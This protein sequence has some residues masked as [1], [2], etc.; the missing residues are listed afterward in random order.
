MAALGLGLRAALVVGEGG[1]ASAS[2]NH[3]LAEAVVILDDVEGGALEKISAH[4]A[5]GIAFD[6]RSL[7]ELGD[8]QY[9]AA[10]RLTDEAEAGIGDTLVA[11]VMFNRAEAHVSWA[12]WLRQLGDS[13]GLAARWAA[14]SDVAARS[15]SFAMPGAWHVELMTLGHLMAA[16]AGV[17][18]AAEVQEV[19]GEVE[20]AGRGDSR[21][22]SHLVLSRALILAKDTQESRQRQY[23]AITDAIE[24][25]DPDTFPLFHD[26]ALF[27]AAEAEAAAGHPYGLRC[28]QR[29]IRHRW[30]DR[31]ARLSAMRAQIA[32]NRMRQDFDRV[33]SEVTRDD[34][35]GIGNRRALAAFTAELEFRGVERAA[36]MMVDLDR[37]KAVN[38]RHGHDAGDAVLARVARVLERTVRP[39]DLAVRLG[40]DEFMVVLADV[41]AQVAADRA[42]RFIAEVDRQPWEEISPGLEVTV[43]VGVAAGRRVALDGVRAAADRAVYES[44]RSGRHRLTCETGALRPGRSGRGA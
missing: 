18:R 25:V 23:E 11:A 9:A 4:T 15:R 20:E 1:P 16:V 39:S 27:L 5:C 28:A 29:Q 37:F 33:S 26:L 32:A 41:S 19:L 8:E 35:T 21:A 38:D 34:L 2:F 24:A 14:W 31:V 13:D 6:F 36:V 40:G 10:L 3:D 17:G 7:W 42:A 12:A 43:S 30:G 44:K 22:A